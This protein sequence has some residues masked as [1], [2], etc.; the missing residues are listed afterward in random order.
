VHRGVYR[1][2]AKSSELYENARAR[3]ARFLNAAHDSEII[4]VRGAT[5][6][7]NLVVQSWGAAFLRPATK[8]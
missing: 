1:L 3:M 4:F 5:E 6:G 7:I 2:S 8:C